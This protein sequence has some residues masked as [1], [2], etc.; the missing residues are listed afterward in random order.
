MNRTVAFLFGCLSPPSPIPTT[1]PNSRRRRLLPRRTSPT[2][3]SVPR[4]IRDRR[5]LRISVRRY[6]SL[7]LLLPPV[8]SVV[9][10][11]VPPLSMRVLRLVDSACSAV[12]A[13]PV[14]RGGSFAHEDLAWRWPESGRDSSG[15][16]SGY[17]TTRR[18]ETPRVCGILSDS[19]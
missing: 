7:D 10:D 9:A 6:V 16:W 1:T 19:A 8:G 5:V 14:L 17:A 13:S 3:S 4:E 15:R 12:S 11:L 18:G 2:R